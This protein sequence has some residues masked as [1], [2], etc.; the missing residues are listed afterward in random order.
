MLSKDNKREK[1]AYFYFPNMLS[2][3][4]LLI[5]NLIQLP[6]I[7]KFNSLFK[8]LKKFLRNQAE[9]WVIDFAAVPH[10]EHAPGDSREENSSPVSP[11]QE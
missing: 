10:N 4:S 2:Q 3:G 7:F 8:L 6:K 9:R 5:N 11:D 1:L